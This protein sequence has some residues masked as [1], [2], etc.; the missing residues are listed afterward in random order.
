MT[1]IE[2]PLDA[3]LRAALAAE[4]DHLDANEQLLC[5]I[6]RS[7]ASPRPARRGRLVASVASIA[8][9]VSVT[10]AVLATRNDDHT[11][12]I[13]D[14]LRPAPAA[15]VPA[16]TTATGPFLAVAR[17]GGTTLLDLSGREVGRLNQFVPM[18]NNDPHD[19]LLVKG[20]HRYLADRS[21]EVRPTTVKPEDLSKDEAPPGAAYGGAVHGHWQARWSSP[22][23]KSRLGAWSGECESRTAWLSIDHGPWTPVFARTDGGPAPSVALGWTADGRAIVQVASAPCGGGAETSGTY[24]VGIDGDRT[25]VTTSLAEALWIP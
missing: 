9:V 5:R 13:A 3:T 12:V 4:V 23:G 1:P 18:W 7:I 16:P 6:E 2:D 25:L 11:S 17:D 24:L 15:T 20:G 14:D 8:L 21:G 10:A 19:L 22:D